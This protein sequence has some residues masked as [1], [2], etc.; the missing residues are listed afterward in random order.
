MSLR[1]G[2]GA[3]TKTLH[4]F[5]RFRQTQTMVV[6]LVS[7]AA[8]GL[9]LQ[10]N[11]RPSAELGH[12]VFTGAG[13]QSKLLES[14]GCS[15]L[16]HRAQ[17]LQRP[18]RAETAG[19]RMSLGLS[20]EAWNVQQGSKANSLKIAFIVTT[21]DSL[22]Q[23]WIWIH[24]HKTIGVGV[25]YIFADGQAARADNV[26]ALRLVPGITVVL[27]DAKLQRRHEASRIWKESWLSAFFHKP[28]N[29]ELFVL[30]SLN[31]EVGIE[32]AQRDGIDWLL[33][34]DT[35]ELVYPSG[36]AEYSLQEVLGKVP[37]DVDTLV[38]PNYESLPETENVVQPFMEVTL[39]KKN[40]AHVVSDLYFKSYGIV[41][42]GNPNYF[43]TYGNG[44][45]AARVQHGM[46]PNGAHRWHSYVKMPKE[47]SSDQ[48]AVLHFTYNRFGDLR[49]RRDRCDC[50]PTEEDAKRCF[51]LPFDRMAFL[52]ASIKNDTE[53]LEWFR[54]H[55]VWS[56]P[57]IVNDLLKKGLLLRIYEPQLIIG[58]FLQALN[59]NGAGNHSVQAVSKME[60]M[61]SITAK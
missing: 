17:E 51:I 18:G 36:S 48:A 11:S 2:S 9:V 57:V 28:C 61:G 30:Q 39:F 55:L 58:G 52:E 40:Y 23:I 12:V 49:S 38:F 14:L 44:K 53:L 13:G 43:I 45:S 34:V 22:Q 25:F 50:A 3:Q 46:R 54:Q 31:M 19:K 59:P 33:H 5:A 29:H 24:Y 41:S 60:D 1:R 7:L 6:M 26:A 56:D 35:D 20:N 42:R 27:R 10:L 8:F 37:A 15:E 4:S 21:S 16:S 32:M 47:S